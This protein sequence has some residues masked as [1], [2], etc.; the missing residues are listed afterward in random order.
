[1]E[2]I[3]LPTFKLTP[4]VYPEPIFD[5]HLIRKIANICKNHILPLLLNN[6]CVSGKALTLNDIDELGS[7]LGRTI[8]NINICKSLSGFDEYLTIIR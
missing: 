3:F 6:N 8:T 2:E 5:S 1:M 7:Y 4:A